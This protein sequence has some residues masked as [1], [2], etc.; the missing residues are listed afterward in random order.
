MIIAFGIAELAVTDGLADR[1][2]RRPQG[3]PRQRQPR[4]RED[5]P[6]AGRRPPHRRGDR[7]GPSA[8]SS[9][10]RAQACRSCRP[11]LT[12][13]SV[14]CRSDGCRAPRSGGEEGKEEEGKGKG[15]RRGPFRARLRRLRRLGPPRPLVPG[16]GPRP[17]SPRSKHT[18]ACQY[19]SGWL[20]QPRED[21]AS[22][23]HAPE[24]SPRNCSK[25]TP[26][27]ARQAPRAHA[28]H[29]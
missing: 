14:L 21:S 10:D 25:G 1:A 20:P 16:P 5:A 2:A 15:G 18:R 6:A 29:T 8:G 27:G 22:G 23:T 9:A 17:L 19:L 12:W 13:P 26:G 28:D 3:H 4:H 11:R 24:T 7:Q